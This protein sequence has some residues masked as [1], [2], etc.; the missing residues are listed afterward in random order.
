MPPVN[1]GYSLAPSR[2]EALNP[3]AERVAKAQATWLTDP[4]KRRENP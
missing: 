4:A 3:T 1:A 2:T